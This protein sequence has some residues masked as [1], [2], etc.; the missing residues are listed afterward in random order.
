MSFLGPLESQLVYVIDDTFL[1]HTL[2]TLP[3]K[4]ECAPLLYD[5][6]TCMRCGEGK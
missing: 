1:Q 5:A 3:I 6:R 4:M 2:N